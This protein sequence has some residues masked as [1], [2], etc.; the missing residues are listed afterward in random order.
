M[1]YYWPVLLDWELF[2][3]FVAWPDRLH[4]N[5]M[6][7]VMYIFGW[8]YIWTFELRQTLYSIISIFVV[9]LLLLII[10]HF[11]LLFLLLYLHVF[12]G[13]FFIFPVELFLPLFFERV[14]VNTMFGQDLLMVQ[15]LL[16]FLHFYYVFNAHL[17]QQIVGKSC[18]DLSVGLISQ[19]IIRTQ[20]GLLGHLIIIGVVVV[21]FVG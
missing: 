14:N 11:F 13:L 17:L 7:C 1:N 3:S 12:V 2:D 20:S 19:Q 5:T 9:W 15:H 8:I 16:L 4:S 18:L 6:L 21:R 10:Y